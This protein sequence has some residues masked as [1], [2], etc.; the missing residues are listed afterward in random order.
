[1]LQTVV[2]ILLYCMKRSWHSIIYRNKAV[3]NFNELAEC[4]ISDVYYDNGYVSLIE[5]LVLG[6][7][8]SGSDYATDRNT[9]PHPT[10]TMRRLLAA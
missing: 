7:L 5:R 1:M 10:H 2:N 4:K 9:I 3:E 6:G 8:V